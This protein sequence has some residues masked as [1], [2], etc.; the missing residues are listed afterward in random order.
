M[1]NYFENKRARYDKTPI[2]LIFS[3]YAKTVKSFSL[4]RQ[5]ITKIKIAQII[6][7]QELE[8]IEEMESLSRPLSN[9]TDFTSPSL[10]PLPAS[11]PEQTDYTPSSQLKYRSSLQPNINTSEQQNLSSS[12][13]AYTQLDVQPD[14]RLSEQSHT[15]SDQNVTQTRETYTPFEQKNSSVASYII[16]FS[17]SE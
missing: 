5:A 15:F 12:I 4:K 16:Q 1:V 11:S 3:G 7:D 13:L 6:G 9:A 17:P 2:D 8:H 10:T 14:P